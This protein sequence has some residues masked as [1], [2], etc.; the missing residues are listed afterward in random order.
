MRL[1]TCCID[2][3]VGVRS[4][5]LPAHHCCFFW[6]NLPTAHCSPGIIYTDFKPS[7]DLGRPIHQPDVS[8]GTVPCP[9]YIT[10]LAHHTGSKTAGGFSR[11]H[12]ASRQ[13][14]LCTIACKAIDWGYAID[15]ASQDA[16]GYSDGSCKGQKYISQCISHDSFSITIGWVAQLLTSDRRFSVVPE[17]C[18]DGDI[19]AP[20]A[21]LHHTSLQG[22]LVVQGHK[23]GEGGEAKVVSVPCAQG[24][25]DIILHAYS[26][27]RRERMFIWRE[28]MFIWRERM[29]IWLLLISSKRPTANHFKC[30]KLI[31]A[32]PAVNSA[33]C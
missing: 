25:S 18:T 23:A 32:Q 30:S 19:L 8:V 20:S 28:R 1:L 7:I 17:V 21:H 4:I 3:D 5:K 14:G 10:Q 27:E 9:G 13:R 11:H 22:A 15:S 12:S 31:E 6:K 24:Q 2:S 33:K 26:C 29:F 16:L